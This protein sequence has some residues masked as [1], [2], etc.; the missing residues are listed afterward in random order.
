MRLWFLLHGD[1][2]FQYKYGFYFL[3]LIFSVF[4]ISLIFAM[5]EAWR[6]KATILMIFSDP[7]AMGLFFMGAI[8]LFEKSERVLNSIAV[9]PIRSYEY[10]L[11]KL[12]SIGVISV[13]VGFAI[14]SFSSAVNISIYFIM[15][16]F[17]CSCLFSAVGLMVAAKSISLNGFIIS[18]IPAQLIINIPAV[19]W[20]F[21]WRP[22]WLLIHPGVSMMELCENGRRVLLAFIILVFWDL[23]AV[24]MAHRTVKGMFREIGGVKL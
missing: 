8:V 10:I 3:Y 18:T 15:G 12:I 24:L 13:F 17:L 4:Y 23:L 16:I 6:E 9:S 1:I 19:A 20:L 22:G 11:S 21:G 5:P 7:A 14:G 2:R